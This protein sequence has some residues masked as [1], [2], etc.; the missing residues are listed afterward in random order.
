MLG[1]RRRSRSSCGS[2]RDYDVR[3]DGESSIA[4]REEHDSELGK[5]GFIVAESSGRSVSKQ[6]L[7]T[8]QGTLI[9]SSVFVN[10]VPLGYMS[11]VPLVYLLQIGYSPVTI[12]AIYAASG[13][14]NTVGYAPFGV[15]ADRF[16]RKKFLVLGFVLPALPYAIFGFTLDPYLLIVASVI[17]G[18]GLAGGLATAISSPSVLPLLADSSPNEHRTTLF[19]MYQGVYTLGQSVGAFLSFLPSLISPSSELGAVEMA[20]SDSYFIMSGL[21][22]VS[23]LPLFF[24]SEAGRLKT[25]L[26]S[27]AADLAKRTRSLSGFGH[28]TSW[29]KILKF[30][31]VFG[32]SGL[33]FGIVIQLLPTWYTLRFG[34]SESAVGYWMALADLLTLV[35]LPLIPLLMRRHGSIRISVLAGLLACVPLAF[36]PISGTFELAAILFVIRSIVITI[37]IPV[38]QSY[39]A[40]AVSEGERATTFGVVFTAWGLTNSIGTI[41][42][43]D[44]LGANLLTIPFVIGIGAYIVAWVIFYAFF[45]GQNLPEERFLETT[46]SGAMPSAHKASG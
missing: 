22:L 6:P 17:G 16:G 10:S 11:V 13:V 35:A 42:A 9:L 34:T 23:I 46:V 29:S 44:L 39:I 5:K 8:R 3:L 19:A 26:H 38:F 40:G 31:I 45:R 36:M 41:L 2:D 7:L 14:A 37:N 28:V 25:V 18:V 21:T 33:G 4:A 43:G 24:V 1:H 20:H 12:G 15:F 27:T 32:L 30:S